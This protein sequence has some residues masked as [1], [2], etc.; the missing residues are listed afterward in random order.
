M[1]I[2]QFKVSGSMVD[3]HMVLRE[4]AYYEY[5]NSTLLSLLFHKGYTHKRLETIGAD[6]TQHNR[7]IDTYKP[8]WFTNEFMSYLEINPSLD[9]E[10]FV[11][12]KCRFFTCDNELCAVVTC[13]MQSN[14]EINMDYLMLH[15]SVRPVSY[16]TV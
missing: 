7:S 11:Q 5:L 6:L 12:L 13:M 1:H 16:I 4:D 14:P 10:N 15:Q 9:Y 3:D 2:K 8:L